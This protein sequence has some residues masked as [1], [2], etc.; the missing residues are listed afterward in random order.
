MAIE[1]KIEEEKITTLLEDLDSLESYIRDLFNFLPLPVFLLSPVKIILEVNPAFEQITDYKI[2][3]VIG[4]SIEGIFNPEEIESLIQETIEK[5]SVKVKE[6]V[7]STKTGEKIP[8]SASTVLRKSEEGDIVGYFF[9]L[10]N[11]TD[12]KK[13]ENELINT[14]KSLLNILEDT[15]EARKAI[16]EEKN[17]TQSIVNNFTDGLLLFN[18]QGKLSLVNP[19]VEKL[20][21]IKQ[22]QIIGFSVEELASLPG[23]IP[24]VELLG[25]E[26]KEAF[27]KEII[28]K[29]N[30]NLEVSTVSMVSDG[31]KAETLVILHDITREKIIEK[32]K[33]EFVSLA[34]H[35]LRTPLSAIKWTLRMLLDGDLGRITQEQREFIDKS[36]ISNERMIN[37]INDLLDV[38]RIEE[39]RYLYKPVLSDI[40]EITE[41]VVKSY[42]ELI[43]RKK[44][45]FDLKKP[46]GKMPKVLVDVEKIRLA[47]ENLLNNAIRYTPVGGKVV[48][49]LS[50]KDKEVQFSV[51]DSG[52]GIPEDQQERIFTKF[53]RATNA[54]RIET[55]GS[56]LGLF[57]TKNIIEAH[58]GKIWFKSEVDKGS[59]FYFTLPV[60]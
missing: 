56:G 5:G 13:K 11:L 10:F 8:V 31:Q 45:K 28:V 22:D 25:G 15:E 51:Q 32:M 17:K 37:L 34:A 12:I 50:S 21:G 26:I 23:F 47:I 53:F 40:A 7:L 39:G 29:D 9:S 6:M 38:T 52:A 44:I 3:E 59:T 60:E 30:L 46:A 27:R 57:I 16:E 49:S 4:R 36:Y 24:L 54:V 41:F 2:E 35:Q 55:E 14:Q 33:T 20:F 58:D 19:Q 1:K 18:Q 42:Q 43:K 48:I